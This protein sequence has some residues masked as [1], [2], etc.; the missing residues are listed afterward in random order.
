MFFFQTKT[1]KALTGERAKGVG[2]KYQN[3]VC[4]RAE[5]TKNQ[6]KIF[7]ARKVCSR[8]PSFRH[9]RLFR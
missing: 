1:E 6:W 7:I 5:A 8:L 2:G 3:I 9:T 4:P